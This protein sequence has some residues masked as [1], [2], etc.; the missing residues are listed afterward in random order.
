MKRISKG[1]LFI[2]I[3]ILGI[4][5]S[6][7]AEDAN[8][9]E[10]NKLTSIKL[11]G[12]ELEFFNED[13]NN[14][15]ITVES[16]VSKINI[17]ATKKDDKAEVTGDIGEKKLDY[18]LNKFSIKVS[19]NSGNE[20]IYHLD[21]TRED[22]RSDNNTLKSLTLSTGD[23][24][25]KSD[26]TS[27]SINVDNNVEK[28]TIKSELSDIK[29]R[30][31]EDYR[32]KEIELVE[33]SN[34]VEIKIISEKGDIK[35]YTLNINRALSGNNSLKSLKVNDDK[36]KLVENEF[37]YDVTVENEV[38]EVVI[39]AVTNDTKA[40]VNLEDKYEL[41]VGINEIKIKVIAANG[42]E[43]SYILN[44]TR[45]KILSRDSLLTNIR[46]K[47]YDLNF[48]QDVKVYNLKIN[49]EGSLEISTLKEDENAVVE[50]EGNKDL[51]DG[52]IIKI[53]VKAEDGSFTRYFINIEK[54]KKGISPVLIILIVLFILLGGC[55]GLIFYRKNK[56]DK[57]E[58]STKDF[59]K[60]ETKEIVEI[61]SDENKI[62]DTY[63]GAHEM[64]NEAS[65]NETIDKE[66]DI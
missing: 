26:V 59:E 31:V 13:V 4:S 21:I 44:I 61:P 46:I 34:K 51:I 58:F 28:I 17:T 12:H 60:S 37:I 43:A 7:Y 2:F 57:K 5:I 10:S 54:K 48:K 64:T 33:G 25:F 11:D 9:I 16:D 62:E 1:L 8:N 40:T 18:G 14:Y 38:S 39:D 27:Y 20:N 29:S 42:S 22:A 53:N 52:S 49:D 19:S 30:Y 24:K 45:K 56:K 32:N 66:K 23:I 15:E 6:V 41:Q 63:I 47:G 65:D 50:I 36:I 55:I 3:L 35:I